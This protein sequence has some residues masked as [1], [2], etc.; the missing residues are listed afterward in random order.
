[1]SDPSAV[2]SP[3]GPEAYA[4]AQSVAVSHLP[5]VIYRS[6]ADPPYAVEWMVG[7]LETL[8]GYNASD[9]SE[10]GMMTFANVLHPDDLPRVMDEITACIEQQRSW[11]V[12]YRVQH[13]NGSLTWVRGFGGAVFSA[14][15]KIA[16]LEG[17]IIDINE[18]Q[19][20]KAALEDVA[21]ELE[22][23]NRTMTRG[24]K[25]LLD[26]LQS[27]DIL[28]INA[29][30][31]AARA[32]SAGRGFAIVAEEMKRLTEDAG[33]AV[34]EIRQMIGD[35]RV[36]RAK[37]ADDASDLAKRLSRADAVAHPDH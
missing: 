16:Y 14:D 29:S 24:V 21:K 5:G 3:T 2:T 23:R 19:L 8:T 17:V 4:Q 33:V 7:Q 27:I 9:F 6:R 36:D 32:G 35:Q 20:A 28:S 13:R 10:G 1:M 30:I 37:G 18:R 31:E 34:A 22:D 12:E 11:D 15:R 26:T 25:H